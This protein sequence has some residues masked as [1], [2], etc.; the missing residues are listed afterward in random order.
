MGVAYSRR[1]ELGEPHPWEGLKLE[2]GL[3][4][5]EGLSHPACKVVGWQVWVG[6]D[7]SNGGVAAL[8]R[9]T[10]SCVGVSGGLPGEGDSP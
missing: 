3:G 4:Q 6:T 2:C 9:A 10:R 1:V 7:V 5:R 8:I